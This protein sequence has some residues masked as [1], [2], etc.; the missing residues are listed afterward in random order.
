MKDAPAMSKNRPR[1]ALFS[2]SNCPAGQYSLVNVFQWTLFSECYS[3]WTGSLGYDVPTFLMI[4]QV[5]ENVS[6]SPALLAEHL[7]R[8]PADAFADDSPC[9]PLFE[10]DHPS[11]PTLHQ[12]SQISQICQAICVV[13]RMVH[14]MW[15]PARFANFVNK[16]PRIIRSVRVS[17]FF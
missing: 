1:L 4:H 16:R 11:H 8:W 5:R 2:C 13:T 17:C 15:W 7:D 10:R 14:G 3:H 6:H 12:L 9:R